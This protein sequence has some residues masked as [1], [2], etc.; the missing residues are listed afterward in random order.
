MA[1]NC[2]AR[3]RGGGVWSK[4][5]VQSGGKLAFEMCQAGTSGGALCHVKVALCVNSLQK[6]ITNHLTVV[7]KLQ[8]DAKENY[9]NIDPR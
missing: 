9:A 1:C 7:V 8:C 2:S 6:P 3:V 4:D 5:V